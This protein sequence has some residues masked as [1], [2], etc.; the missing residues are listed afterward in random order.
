M[1]PLSTSSKRG[2]SWHQALFRRCTFVVLAFSASL[3]AQGGRNGTVTGTISNQA[4]GDLL[5]G[6]LVTVEG[7]GITTTAERG[8]M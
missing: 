2:A 7:T 5:Q 4:T 1:K 6:A 3:F 8:G